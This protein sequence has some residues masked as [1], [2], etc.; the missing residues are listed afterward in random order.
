MWYALPETFID[1]DFRSDM[2][3]E[4]LPCTA[5]ATKMSHHGRNSGV[6]VMLLKKQYAEFVQEVKV[7]CENVLVIEVDEVLFKTGKPVFMIGV[8]VPPC[9]PAC[10][11]TE[12]GFGI[13]PLKQ[14]LLNLHEKC[15]DLHF[16]IF[17]GM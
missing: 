7:P 15:S 12:N 13:E 10:R 1:S 8:N 6:G 17:G 11:V 4:Y 3:K 16:I 5:K 2:F 9:L 14:C